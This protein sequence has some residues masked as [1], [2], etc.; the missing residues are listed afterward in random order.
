M[1]WDAP[2]TGS[3]AIYYHITVYETDENGDRI[4]N[5]SLLEADAYDTRFTFESKAEWKGR[6]FKVSVAG[7]NSKGTGTAAASGRQ[8]FVRALPTPE[9][10][11]RLMPTPEEG[12]HVQFSQKL[13]LTNAD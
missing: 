8:Q 4:G 13:V 3:P 10:E 2:T 11:V 7:V 1:T 9:L 6:Y 12:G 5:T